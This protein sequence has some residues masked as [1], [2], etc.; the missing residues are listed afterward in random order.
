SEIS[1]GQVRAGIDRPKIH[2]SDFELQRVGS[3]ADEEITPE[4]TEFTGQAVSHVESHGQSGCGHR[5]S[6]RQSRRR[7]HFPARLS[8]ER[9]AD[10]SKKH[11][12]SICV[13]QSSACG[14]C[15]DKSPQA[16]A[17]ATSIT[18]K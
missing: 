2:S 3:V 4:R 9:I 8:R 18:S 16:E 14:G 12:A 1:L 10:N 15:K 11:K 6:K 13:A 17:C 5:H 7:E